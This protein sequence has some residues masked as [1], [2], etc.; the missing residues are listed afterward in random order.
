MGNV[1]QN[2]TNILGTTHLSC[3]KC[4]AVSGAIRVMPCSS[5]HCENKFCDLCHPDCRWI[6]LHHGETVRFDSGKG[7]GPFCKICMS[8]QM[9]EMSLEQRE[10]ME[11]MALKRRS[12][13]RLEAL[14]E[15]GS[16]LF[17]ARLFS[18]GI[19]VL[20]GIIVYLDYHVIPSDY[21][22]SLCIAIPTFF[23]WRWFLLIKTRYHRNIVA[24]HLDV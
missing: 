10:R 3:P 14:E 24:Y 6:D 13:Q 21:V 23:S 7:E 1:E 22:C 18:I 16:E 4:G 11:E 8:E 5:Q 15:Q 9:K 17:N 12:R 20:L 19:T 2:I